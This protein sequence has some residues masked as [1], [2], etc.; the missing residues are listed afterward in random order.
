MSRIFIASAALAA[1]VPAAATAVSFTDRALFD[2][3]VPG[4]VSNDL[5]A[6]PTGVITTVFALETIS[7]SG[8]AAGALIDPYNASFGQALGGLDSASVQDNFESV[9]FTFNAPVYAFGFDDLDL[10][11]DD[12]EYAN[13]RLDFA[14]GATLVF[15]ISETD[16]D[17]DTAAFFGFHS[18]IAIDRVEIWSSDLAGGPIGDRANVVDNLAISRTPAIPEPAS[19]AMLIVGFGTV[20]TALRRRKPVLA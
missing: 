9:I 3:A 15:S 5:N 13:V 19:W 1:L 4:I 14:N 17:F 20:G 16:F 18:S 10:T 12:S 2:L 7:S 6:L 8:N 11:G